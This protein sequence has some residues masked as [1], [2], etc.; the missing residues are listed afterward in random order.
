MGQYTRHTTLGLDEIIEQVYAQWNVPRARYMAEGKY[1]VGVSSLRMKTFGRAA[2]HS[3]GL[4]CVSCNLEAKFFAVESFCRAQDQTPHV[5]LYG[6]ND[7][8]NEVLFTHDHI[9]A[10]SLGGADNLTNSQIMCSPCNNKK[11]RGEHK[12]ANALKEAKG[13][14]IHGSNYKKAKVT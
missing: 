14:P 5:N 13:I 11:S 1:F 12:L 2:H 3:N 8:G 10:R 4:R 9:L 7:N 6:V